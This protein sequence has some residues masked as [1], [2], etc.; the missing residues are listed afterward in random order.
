MTTNLDLRASLA[1]KQARGVKQ[2]R[3]STV[4]AEL[5]ETPDAAF[6]EAQASDDVRE[7]RQ[8]VRKLR[9]RVKA[10]ENERK[11]A[12]RD[13]AKK[14]TE[15]R[16]AHAA[17]LA[18]VRAEA[19]GDDGYGDPWHAL[20]S[21][22]EDDPRMYGDIEVKG[23][24]VGTAEAAAILNV[25]RPRIGR[26]VS[27]GK[28]PGPIAILRSTPVW[29]RSDIEDRREDVESRRKP[30]RSASGFPTAEEIQQREARAGQS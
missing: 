17:D 1:D 10:L 20:R 11:A 5:A 24:L 4:L 13:A 12:R 16:E 9:E 30:R 7:M 29:I 15:T 2:I 28:L 22:A 21:M 19:N 23:G 26:W 6:P 18:R 8:E 25:E 14:D 27:L 3:V